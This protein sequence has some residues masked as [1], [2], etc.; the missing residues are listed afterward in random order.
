MKNKIITK[1]ATI[2]VLC[3]T[4]I[5]ARAQTQTAT[6]GTGQNG[7]GSVTDMATAI[8]VLQANLSPTAVVSNVKIEYSTG[9]RK[10]YLTGQV[11]KDPASSIAIQLHENGI[12][13][14]AAAGPGVEL[15][16]TGDNCSDCRISFEG[17]R[18]HC[19]CFRIE[20]NPY[21]C[22][23]TSRITISL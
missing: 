14:Y 18:P 15:T 7:I 3:L 4:I 19:K 10:Y 11:S 1:V 8:K 20:S 6:V 17:G 13:L 23:M 16:C 2:M 12:L 9:E 22:D 21:K 5:S